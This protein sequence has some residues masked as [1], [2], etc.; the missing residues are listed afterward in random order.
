[1]GVLLIAVGVAGMLVSTFADSIGVGHS[2]FGREQLSGLVIG[3]L[4]TVAGLVKVFFANTR[5]LVRVLAGIYVGGILYVG[6]RPNPFNC[7]QDKILLDVSSF[8]WH[9]A[10]MNTMGFIPLGYLIM[11]SFGN[12]GKNQ[13]ANLFKRAIIVAG[14]GGFT[15]MLLEISQYY[16]ISGR[17]S[18]LFDWIF[19][20]LGTLVGSAMYIFIDRK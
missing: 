11:L 1:M 17:Q 8:D 16:L 5:I 15:S 7:T 9:D 6:L 14:F 13:P 2:G 4:V 20:T 19:N 18:S 10:A 3:A 12:R